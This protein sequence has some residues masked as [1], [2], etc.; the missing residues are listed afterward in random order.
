MTLPLR[1]SIILVNH[2]GGA[3]LARALESIAEH[4]P[5]AQTI[6]VDNASTDGSVD[7]LG[8]SHPGV[9]A[10]EAHENLGYAGGAN[11]GAG[12]AQG[13]ILVFL[14]ADAWIGAGCIETICQRFAENPRT[15][16]VAPK[17]YR[18]DGI[19]LDSAG[20]DLEFPL[21]EAPPRGYLQLDRGA[22][23]VALP[24]AYAS[25]AAL[26]IRADLFER[27]GG[28]DAFFW[29][30][31]EDVDLCWRARMQGYQCIY[32]PRAVARHLGSQAFGGSSSPHKLFLQTR[33]RIAM[34]LQN[35][36]RHNLLY[37]V[38]A[39][40]LHG[41]ATIAA[42]LCTRRYRSIGAAYLK[43]W[44]AALG[45]LPQIARTRR[46]RQRERTLGDRDVLSLHHRVGLGATFRRYRRFLR[47]PGDHLFVDSEDAA[48]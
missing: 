18:S 43:G 8:E 33:N 31:V 38:F 15:A 3:S 10:I 35:L 41:G 46:L 17:I 36:E 32:E 11:L 47:G 19:R 21:G 29:C 7:R 25:G 42:A 2:N 1:T 4:A 30:Y 6:V 39:E 16:I 12:A 13:E 44:L 20:G 45:R 37:F 26:A 14:N 9:Q 5:S 23:D 48:G 27:L 22:F 34:S 24:V 28:F 40:F